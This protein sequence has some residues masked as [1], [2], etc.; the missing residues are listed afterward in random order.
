MLDNILEAI[1]KASTTDLV[2]VLALPNIAN[3][4]KNVAKLLVMRYKNNIDEIINSTPEELSMIDGVGDV[5]AFEIQLF[6]K[7]SECQ[8]T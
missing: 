1:D 7:R 6:F 5:I 3:I 4:G 8:A 2:N